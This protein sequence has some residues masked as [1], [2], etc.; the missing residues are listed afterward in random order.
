M[1]DHLLVIIGWLCLG[2]VLIGLEV[3]APGGILGAIGGLV[4]LW[5]CWLAFELGPLWGMGAVAA[6][7]TAAIALFAAFSRSRAM[8]KLV[9]S[10]PSPTTWHAADPGL[11]GLHGQ[12]GIALTALRPAGTAEIDGRRVDVVAEGGALIDRGSAIEVTEVEGTRVAVIAVLPSPT[13]VQ[14]PP[15]EV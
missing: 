15:A 13:L 8:K 3:L 10:D 2:W 4:L 5:A 1:P 7:V 9:L 12:R 11:A 6:S 14:T